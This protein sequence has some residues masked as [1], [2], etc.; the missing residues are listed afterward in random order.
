M[1][2]LQTKYAFTTE[3]GTEI[4]DFLKNSEIDEWI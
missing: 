2:T 4:E 1:H 3:K